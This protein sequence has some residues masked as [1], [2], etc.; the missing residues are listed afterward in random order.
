KVWSVFRM[1]RTWLIVF[2]ADV[3]IRSESLAQAGAIYSAFV[4]RLNL[5]TLL[6]REI[7]SYGLSK[8]DFMLL[9]VVL[10]IWLAVS[11]LEERGEDVR[12]YFAARPAVV[13]WAFYYGIV[14]LV[15]VTGIYGG[16]YDTA[17]FMYQSF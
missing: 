4:T 15:L 16:G 10:L 7:T 3:L 6:S 5:R 13:R 2:V 9:T 12:T 14:L 1:A 11:V 8:Y 17:A